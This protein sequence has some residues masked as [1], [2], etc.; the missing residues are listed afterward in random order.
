[1]PNWGDLPDDVKQRA[2]EDVLAGRKGATQICQELQITSSHDGLTS[3]FRKLR[4]KAGMIGQSGKPTPKKEPAELRPQRLLSQLQRRG[5][6][7]LD[8]LCNILDCSP[9]ALERAVVKLQEQGHPIVVDEREVALPATPPP[10][11]LPAVPPMWARPAGR[12]A[13]ATIS[14]THFGSHAAQKSALRLFMRI[15]W[16]EYGVD[17]TLHSG[18]WVA[19]VDVYR[20]QE[21]E[22]YA[23]GFEEQL[24]DIINDLP[25]REGHTY[26]GI[27]GNHDFSFYKS[28]QVD[29]M[30]RLEA[31]R[32]DIISYGW[33]AADVPLTEAADVRLWHPSG[34]VPYALSYRGQKYAAQVAYQELID[35]VM[36]TKPAPRVRILQIGHLH[37]MMG[38]MAQGPIRVYQAGCFEGNNSYLTRKGLMPVVGGYIF[39]AE[40][41]DNG[42]IR[43]LT[44]TDLQ[45]DMMVDDWRNHRQPMIC[46]L[47]RTETVY[48]FGEL[49]GAREWG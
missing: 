1:M 40:I 32:P 9:R 41:T 34:G 38:P 12:V 22:I 44:T 30:R 19:G 11:V 5:S 13:W 21:Y 20:G 6:L 15:A 4:R 3:Y 10:I 35:V 31:E 46:Q 14:D 48:H 49:E 16:E 42:L 36:G 25:H 39:Q 29:F 28:G 8:D 24:D 23:A 7:S 18:D 33:D 45:F 26:R 47:A 43:K 2:I 37:V 27:G 17:V